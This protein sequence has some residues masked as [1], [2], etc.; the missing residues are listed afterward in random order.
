MSQAT[1]RKTANSQA[2]A[3]QLHSIHLL[4][5]GEEFAGRLSSGTRTFDCRYHPVKGQIINGQ[6]TFTGSFSVI[7]AG[8]SS[9]TIDSVTATLAAIQAGYGSGPR[10]PAR[11][12][13]DAQAAPA[14]SSPNT[15]NTG[16]RGYAGVIYFHLTPMDGRRL[17]LN[18]D[19]RKVQLNVRLAPVNDEERD[20]QWLLSAITASLLGE[21]RDETRSMG[22]LEELNRQ[23]ST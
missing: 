17:G 21:S 9:R 10:P 3:R 12:Q 20:L 19:L 4:L 13:S 7:G 15:E 2:R 5:R 1:P 11:F 8:G 22:Y 18:L 16:T 6:L 14:S 23:L